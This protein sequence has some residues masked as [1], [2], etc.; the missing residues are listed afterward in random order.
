MEIWQAAILG[1]VQGLTE[2]LPVSSSGHVAFFNAIF[3]SK[4]DVTFF[5][6][7]LHLGTLVAVCVVFW[8]DIIALFKKPFKTLGLLVLASIPAAVVGVIIEFCKLDD[9][10]LAR[11]CV[12]IVLSVFFLVTATL[13]FVTEIVAKRRESVL[14]LCI[15]TALPM[16]FAQAVAVLPGIS[17]SGST[18]CAGTLAG[19]NREDV[20]KFSFLM[21]IPVILGGFLVELVLGLY[22]GEIQQNFADY[23]ATLGWSVALGFIISALAG[24]FA[25]KVMLKVIKKA[26]YKWFSLYLVLM[27]ITSLILQ[28]TVFNA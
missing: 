19:C 7:I 22:K 15:K 21:S 3:D 24:L 12:G 1:L 16:G 10:L 2:F 11:S 27:S 20:A 25:I 18:I 14:P 6:L 8:R 9:I 23:G 5:T 26:N 4:V 28:F 13:L 17:R